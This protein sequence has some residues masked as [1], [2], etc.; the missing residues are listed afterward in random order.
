M[1]PAAENASDVS[2]SASKVL[3]V[4]DNFDKRYLLSCILEPSFHVLQAE[5]GRKALTVIERDQPD[6]VLLDVLMPE[7][8]GFEVCR[9]MKA[10]PKM[11][12]IPVLFVTV[13]NQNETRVEGLELGA[14]DFISWPI[15]ASELVARVRARVRSSRPLTHLRNVLEEQSR[16]LEMERER[17]AAT[18]YELEQARRVQERFVTN[19]FPQGR[20]LQFAHRYRPSRQVG[21]DLFDVVPVNSSELVMIMADISG[22]GVPAALLTS[23]TKVLFRTGVEQCSNPA[24]LI[25][26]LNRQISSYLATGEFITVFLGWW[27]LNTQCF[28]YAGAG[29]PPALAMSADGSHIEWL[30]VSQGIIGVIPEQEFAQHETILRHG[31]RVICYTDGITETTNVNQE[32]FG[33]DRLAEACRR[34]HGVSVATMVERVFTEI[35]EFAGGETQNDDQALLAFEVG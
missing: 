34:Q 30:H 32:F 9:R 28:T 11:A 5:N 27:N 33:E 6:V 17:E 3:V 20:G 23:V 21:G 31:T 10:D 12:E 4:D 22:H 15:N 1:Q 19:M 18:K 14:E 24:Q 26:W 25:G 29:H 7:L 2:D 13:L 16:I 35:D 8:D